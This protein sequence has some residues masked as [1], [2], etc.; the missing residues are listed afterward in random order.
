MR[1]RACVNQNTN[2][3]IK[4][5]SDNGGRRRT[6]FNIS[7]QYSS[8]FHIISKKTCDVRIRV[9]FIARNF[10]GV[11]IFRTDRRGC[12]F[13]GLA[14]LVRFLI[15]ANCPRVKIAVE[16]QCMKILLRSYKTGVVPPIAKDKNQ[17]GQSS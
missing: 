17:R 11:R 4:N 10:G 3:V 8:R 7:L 6:D 15:Q 2:A 16:S 13:T 12:G 14:W 9:L 5:F 1:R